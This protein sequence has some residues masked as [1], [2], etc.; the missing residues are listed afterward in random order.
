[1][2]PMAVVWLRLALA[3]LLAL[4]IAA[5]VASPV[6]KAMDATAQTVFVT[7]LTVCVLLLAPLS[8]REWSNR[9]G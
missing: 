8:P 9:R 5:L 6:A 4:F 7:V 2:T 1:M 3:V